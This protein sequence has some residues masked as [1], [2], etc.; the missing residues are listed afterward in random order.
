MFVHPALW[1]MPENE[2]HDLMFGKQFHYISIHSKQEGDK[3]FHATTRFDWYV[4]QNQS[5]NTPTSVRFDDGIQC[6]LMINSAL[7]FIVNHGLSII[8]KMMLKNQSGF[9]KCEKV[10]ECH[11]QL[12]HVSKQKKETYNYPLVTSSS[13]TRGF[14]LCWSNRPTKSQYSKKVILSDGEVITPFYDTGKFGTTESGMFILVDT[15]VEGVHITR[16]LK[17][18]LV[19]FVNAAC[20]W[21]NFATKKYIFSIIPHPKDLP[22]NFT[23]AQVYAYFGL[24][25]EEIGR[26]EANQRGPGLANYVALEAPDVSESVVVVGVGAATA[27]TENSY[28]NMSLA[29]LKSIC[30]EKNIK[31]VSGKKKDEL[32]QL[33]SN[34]L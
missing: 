6:S 34:S 24:T 29:E 15:D 26:I 25:P 2:L 18:K 13:K 16:Y 17:S 32:L 28:S 11:T 4:L 3:V 20:K 10:S 22:D 5:S 33:I 27:A 21:S 19:S 23:D 1:R 14:R 9:L 31:G 12:K 8:Q 30:K 7:P